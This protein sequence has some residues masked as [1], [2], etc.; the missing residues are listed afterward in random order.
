VSVHGHEEFQRF[1]V[2]SHDS[3]A[4]AEIYLLSLT[5]VL[6]TTSQSTFGYVAQG[7]GGLRPWVM[8][9]PANRHKGAGSTVR[10][11]RV[12]GSVFFQPPNYNLWQNQWLDA[13]KIVPHPHVSPALPR[14]PPGAA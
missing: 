9:K 4:W 14:L 8:Y 5:D 11:G 2:R 13:S 6:A 10:P 3:K 12:N 1:G 7:L